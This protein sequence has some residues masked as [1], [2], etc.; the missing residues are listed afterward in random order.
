[1]QR[2][3][4]HLESKVY[5]SA[6]IQPVPK[7][8]KE[9]KNISRQVNLAISSPPATTEYLKWSDQPVRFSRTDHP[10]KVPRPGHAPMVLKAQIGGYDVGRVLMDA[11]SGIN[12]I[13]ARTLKAM[14]IS[15]ESLKPTDC[16]FHRIV[17]GG[18]N[19]PLRK[20]E[21]DVCFGNSSNYRRE[22]LEF[23]VM[24]WPSQYHAILGTQHLQSSW[25]YLITH[26]SHSKFQDLKEQSWCKAALK[27][28]TPVTKNSTGWRKLSA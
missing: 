22:K 27:Y 3:A 11:G 20:I 5:I 21:L 1:M 17:P 26:I 8:K 9:R 28:L 24:D 13:Y 10:R 23:E 15:L 18:A 6:M 19:Y 2:L 25:Q 12:L 16:S 14:C 4:R 7:S